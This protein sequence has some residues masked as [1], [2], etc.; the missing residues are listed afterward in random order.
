MAKDISACV[1]VRGARVRVAWVDF[2]GCVHWDLLVT[3]TFDPKRVFPVS[4]SRSENEAL[5]WCG[6]VGWALRHPIAWL[7]APERHLSG[8]WHA[9]VLLAGV[10]RDISGLAN[11][12]RMRNGHIH[13]QPVTNGTRA[14]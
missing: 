1:R 13:V 4:C 10:P 11:L 3:L 5:K 2:L 8:L 6:L 7:I 9:H 14:V 12:W